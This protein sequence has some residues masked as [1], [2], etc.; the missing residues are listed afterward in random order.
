MAFPFVSM[1]SK[2]AGILAMPAVV[3]LVLGPG[4][5]GAE[6]L[7]SDLF[8]TTTLERVAVADWNEYRAARYE[9]IEDPAER[10]RSIREDTAFDAWLAQRA[11]R[12]GIEL[13]PQGQ[14]IVAEYRN[15]REIAEAT[16]RLAASFHPS[17]D[18]V[19]R[20]AEQKKWNEP[21]PETWEVLYIFLDHTRARTPEERQAAEARAGAVREQLTPENFSA[22][23][24]LWSDAPSS[25]EGGYLGSITL[26]G[27]GP[28][29]KSHLLQTPPG[30]IGGPYPTASGWNILYVRLHREPRKREAAHEDHQ[31]LTAVVLA[32]ERLEETRRSPEGWNTLRDALGLTTDTLLRAEATAY[33][34]FLLAKIFLAE[35]MKTLSPTEEELRAVFAEIGDR[36]RH[37]P[38]RRAREIFLTAPDWTLEATREAWEK[39]RI[40]RDQARELRRRILDGEDFAALAREVSASD[41]ATSGGDLGWIQQPSAYWLDSALEAMAPGEISPPVQTRKGFHLLQLLEVELH[42]PMTFEEARQ[43]CLRVWIGRQSKAQREALAAEFRSSPPANSC[44][45]N[46]D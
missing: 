46:S 8:A 14:A 42:R 6:V 7:L 41:S 13:D 30:T 29:F 34:N 22:M 20:M 15:R 27:L 12:E 2:T 25:T 40:V 21:L 44:M 9:A 18:D 1:L 5:A 23:A 17:P 16:A 38:R 36:F 35:R 32:N 45:P 3:F 4:R 39:R 37:P 33:Q 31:R 28:T 19:R 26:D 11:A 43:E 24:R 10:L